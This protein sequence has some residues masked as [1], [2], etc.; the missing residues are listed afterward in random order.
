MMGLPLFSRWQ[1]DRAFVAAPLQSTRPQPLRLDR[2]P[3]GVDNAHIDVSLPV[4]LT[5]A[6]STWVHALVREEVHRSF[7]H[8]APTHPDRQS[9]ESFRNRYES[10]SRIVVHETRA[11][12]RPE[13]LQLYLVAMLKLLLSEVDV[14]LLHLREELEQQRSDA[15]ARLN[16]HALRLHEQLV[17]LSRHLGLVRYRCCRQVIRYWA[18]QEQGG[19]R[20]LRETVLG[21]AWPVPEALLFNPLL[22]LGG[23]GSEEAFINHYPLLLHDEDTVFEVQHIL[24]W[25]L[26]DWLPDGVG[27]GLGGGGAGRAP[28]EHRVE[29]GELPGYVEVERRLQLL[30]APGEL[31]AKS[32]SWFDEPDNLARLLGGLEAGGVQPG[33]WRHPRWPRQ[34]A[35]LVRRLVGRLQRAG[36][37]RRAAAAYALAELY[38]GTGLKDST[39]MLF[40]FLVGRLSRGKLLRRLEGVA[41]VVDPTRLMKQLQVMARQVAHGQSGEAA[42]LLAVR[43]LT[44]F[45]RLRRDLKLGWQAYRAMDAIRL[46]K[47]PQEIALSRANGLL[48]AFYET[49]DERREAMVLGHVIIKADVRGST[50]ITALMRERN[51]NPAAYFSR[52]LY[53]PINALL[54]TYG[55]SKV[56][57]EGDAVILMLVVRPDMQ[58]AVARAC[59]LAR[60]ILGVI[61]GK[62]AESRRLGL[63]ELEIGLGIAYADEPPTY[64]YD[65]GRQITISPA[66]N[67]ADLLSS[68]HPSM[69]ALAS[70]VL[71][72][73]QGL[74]VIHPVSPGRQLTK[75]VEQLLRY[76]VN[77]IE[78][79]SAAFQHLRRELRLRQ[80][81]EPQTDGRPA[82]RFH[83]GRFQD[84]NGGTHRLV[85]R[86]SPVWLLVGNELVAGDAAGR[87][88]YEVI[89]D[90][91]RIQQLCSK[92]GTD[93]SLVI[94]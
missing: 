11:R 49:A 19:V 81:L 20:K 87:S 31:S 35:R 48:Q 29:Q 62:N 85:V 1:P 42:R 22:E 39:A 70:P 68:C 66:I 23:L 26:A 51:L 83:I 61:Q 6:A 54:K 71:H 3:L 8:D 78:L 38:P 4:E 45:C 25:T 50:R 91:E 72:A 30:V 40:D 17:S 14:A 94:S 59:G 43:L 84:A 58:L 82:Q 89:T 55:A 86:E 10:L 5:D 32:Y 36:L 74:E 64:L 34:Q 73:R 65:E 60:K 13:W 57:V 24:L 63:P 46:L 12:A 90:P 80:L 67:R 7:W 93:E 18:R 53:G 77:G 2:F 88:F 33:P 75:D 47:E 27:E 44:D 56:F 41:T 69:K 79:E 92:A 21:V 76:N 9:A 15:G 28:M 37:L 52:N 16:G